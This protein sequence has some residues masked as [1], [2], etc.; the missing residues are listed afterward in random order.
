MVVFQFNSHSAQDQRLSQYWVNECHTFGVYLTRKSSVGH[1]VIE[2]HKSVIDRSVAS[3]VVYIT[4][5]DWFTGN[6]EQS[7]SPLYVVLDLNWRV[8]LM[9]YVLLDIVTLDPK[10][11]LMDGRVKWLTD[12]TKNSNQILLYFFSGFSHKYNT[13]IN[14][15][16]ITDLVFENNLRKDLD[17]SIY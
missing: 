4:S 14:L 8:L 15:L 9:P 3:L 16:F 17:Q 1:K 7:G 10:R 2:S 5:K 12:P 13:K 11:L 6:S